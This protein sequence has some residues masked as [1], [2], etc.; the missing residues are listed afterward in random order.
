MTDKVTLRPEPTATAMRMALI[1][2]ELRLRGRTDDEYGSYM[3][4]QV[5]SRQA[6]N[7]IEGSQQRD[8]TAFPTLSIRLYVQLIHVRSGENL[9]E[10]VNSFSSPYSTIQLYKYGRKISRALRSE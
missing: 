4:L 3:P 10:F 2:R 8:A 7:G 5:C 6:H 1:L 9:F